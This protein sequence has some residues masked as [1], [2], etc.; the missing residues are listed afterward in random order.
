MANNHE[1]GRLPNAEQ[2]SVDL[3]VVAFTN[4]RKRNISDVRV[5]YPNTYQKSANANDHYFTPHIPI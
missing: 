5:E 2:I 4:S 3:V 1:P